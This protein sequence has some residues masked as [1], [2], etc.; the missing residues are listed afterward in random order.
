MK[1]ISMTSRKS[2]KKSQIDFLTK[3]Y[4]REAFIEKLETALEQDW[5]SQQ[6]SALLILD[7]DHFKEVN[8]CMGHGMGD[9]VLQKTADTLQSF[10]RMND[11]VGRLG[12]DE[13]VVFARNIRNIPAFEQRIK[14]LNRL[15]CKVY[16]K[17]NQQV[18]VSAS[19]GIVLTGKN[20][21][22]FQTLYEKAD[23]ALYRVKQANRN[24][25]QIDS[26]PI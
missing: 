22:S 1:P 6:T 20:R 15:L 25:Y 3:L 11:L 9:I 17:G 2:R 21:S 13:F 26:E 5:E 10:F 18:E 23:K 12:G 14:E 8:D 7:L 4:N 24:G 19:I 16:Y